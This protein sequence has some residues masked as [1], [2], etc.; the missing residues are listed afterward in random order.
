MAFLVD[1]TGSMTPYVASIGAIIRALVDPQGTV[2]GKLNAKFPDMTFSFR[3]ALMGFRDIDDS[4]DQFHEVR[5]DGT[6]HF[7]ENTDRVVNY[8]ESLAKRTFGGC[9]IAEDWLG[10]IE[11]RSGWSR[12]GD[13]QSKVKFIMV[14][15]DA[16]AH[17]FGSALGGPVATLD[18]YP[19]RHPL[20][21]TPD[22]V[23]DGLINRGIGLFI[24]SFNPSATNDTEQELSEKY[25]AHSNNPEQRTISTVPLVANP[26]QTAQTSAAHTTRHVV[27]V[28]DQSGSMSGNWK[29]VVVAYRKYIQQSLQN[30]CDADL[31]SV[32]QFDSS[33]HLTARGAPIRSAPEDL[34]YRGGGTCFYPAACN[35]RSAD[36]SEIST[37]VPL[38]VFMS[39]GQAND[40]SQAVR[41]FQALNNEVK[42]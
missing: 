22:T 30:Q 35:A 37:H 27:F 4:N 39:D 13:W 29:G 33:S 7:T 21:L 15:T 23:V 18:S 24:C 3:V 20:G 28:L 40:T 11:R 42:S 2:M 1:V 25:L 32:V 10:A 31:V 41:Q 16:P 8:M 12:D 34:Y 14:L 9:D 36:L 6:E 5:W 17:G 19:S 38:V 26:Q